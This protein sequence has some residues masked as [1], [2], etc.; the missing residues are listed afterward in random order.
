MK[1][2][3]RAESELS[4]TSHDKQGKFSQI[5]SLVFFVDPSHAFGKYDKPP[6]DASRSW[7]L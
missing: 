7:W 5:M 3:V 1:P 2:L 4:K 6:L